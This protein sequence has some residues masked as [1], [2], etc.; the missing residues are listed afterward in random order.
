MYNL[1]EIEIYF[2]YILWTNYLYC[3]DKLN[4]FQLSPL[5]DA[6]GPLRKRTHS[7]LEQYIT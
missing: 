4:V 2:V 5:R 6:V 3:I 7:P 1:L